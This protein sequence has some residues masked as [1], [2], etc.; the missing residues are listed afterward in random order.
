MA[1]PTIP[2]FIPP[3]IL[4]CTED[5]NILSGIVSH[6][7]AQQLFF[8]FFQASVLL[9][10]VPVLRSILRFFYIPEYFAEITTGL[11]LGPS[12]LGSIPW[13]K[14]LLFSPTG[15]T[16]LQG[17][18]WTAREVYAFMAGLEMDI[19][20]V[21]SSSWHARSLVLVGWCIA[22]GMIPYVTDPLQ[23]LIAPNSTLS[24]FRSLMVFFIA[25]T[26]STTQARHATEL[27]LAI[28]KVGQLGVSTALLNDV[29][30]LT[31]L[32]LAS[33]EPAVARLQAHGFFME[34]LLALSY[35]LVCAYLM[36]PGIHWMVG[37]NRKQ[38]IHISDTTLCVVLAMVTS[39]AQ[40]AALVGYPPMMCS[41][42][43]GMFIPRNTRVAPALLDQLYYPVRS[44]AFPMY[45]FLISLL[46][47]PDELR[48]PAAGLSMLL[49]A[50]LAIAGKVATS[51][52]MGLV[53]KAPLHESLM[54]AFLL[55]IKG[56]P[57]LLL[58]IIYDS[59]LHVSKFAEAF[60]NSNHN[61]HYA[62]KLHLL[63]PHQLHDREYKML[64]TC[65]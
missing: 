21:T 55:S 23:L 26:G 54:T 48:Q 11:L 43:L 30:C 38:R 31:L 13:L 35:P 7:T 59:T 40:L 14:A 45:C 25:N 50:G 6:G 44:V 3:S 2:H 58:I 34:P 51:L 1:S 56:F 57:D 39:L 15:I 27:K 65:K 46:L 37:R 47:K 18:A 62:T 28:T 17:F 12:A 53:F 8:L 49:V 16:A 33:L 42:L 63:I 9:S 32:A 60:G 5:K 52:S 10:V 29:V 41:V 36:G 64:V 4:N 20:L 61:Q 22:C 24:S 19:S